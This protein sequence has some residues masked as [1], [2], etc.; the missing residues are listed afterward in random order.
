MEQQRLQTRLEEQARLLAKEQERRQQVEKELLRLQQQHEESRMRAAQA[1]PPAPPSSSSA[2]STDAAAAV[3]PAAGPP[4]RTSGEGRFPR[5][6]AMPAQHPQTSKDMSDRALDS[7]EDLRH[8][9]EAMLSARARLGLSGSTSVD[10]LRP[11]AAAAAAPAATQDVRTL[12]SGLLAGAAST[13][14]L[15]AA[16]VAGS[17]ASSEFAPPQFP[18]PRG[19]A[20]CRSPSRVHTERPDDEEPVRGT[21]AAKV[22]VFGAMIQK[23]HVRRSA[24]CNG[25]RDSSR[26]PVGSRSFERSYGQAWGGEVLPGVAA[27]V[28]SC[29]FLRAP[30]R[31]PAPLGR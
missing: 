24:S 23:Q 9:G 6:L 13:P 31:P 15:A 30:P 5:A 7:C 8:C 3:R 29:G 22:G 27:P 26:G 20:S 18:P 16:A 14:S 21:V 17:T 19:G 2:A 12:R 4:R 11:P 25:F 1:P 10:R 28:A